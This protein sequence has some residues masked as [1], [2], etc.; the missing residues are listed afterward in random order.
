[1]EKIIIN[2]KNLM[3]VV[4]YAKSIGKE[5]QTI[6]NWIKEKKIKKV[7]FLGKSFVDISTFKG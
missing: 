5:R 1:M 6:Y 7:N 3:T 2:P 4:D